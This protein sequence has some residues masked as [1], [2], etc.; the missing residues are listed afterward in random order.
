MNKQKIYT[1]SI[2]PEFEGVDKIRKEIRTIL[3]GWYAKPEA[4]TFINDFCQIIGELV[5]NAV[6]HGNCLELNGRLTLDAKEAL[7]TLSSN[8][9]PFDPF[10]TVADMPGVNIDGDLPEGGFGLAIIQML[11][12]KA[13]YEFRDGLNIISV[14][15]Y[16]TVQG[17][18]HGVKG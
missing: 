11:S 14:G 4:V 8:G 6:E 18:N 10:L 9:T 5:N 12:D 13:T 15:K 2:K 1:F 7:F 3:A 17:G 16:F